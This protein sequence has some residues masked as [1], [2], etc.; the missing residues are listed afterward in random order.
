MQSPKLSLASTLLLISLHCLAIQVSSIDTLRQGENLNSTSQLISNNGAFSLRFYTPPNSNSTYLALWFTGRSRLSSPVWIGNRRNPIPTNSNPTL[1]LGARGQ[2]TITHDG[3]GAPIDLYAGRSSEVEN[4]TATLTDTGNF[5]VNSN[6]PAGLFWHS[7]DQPSDTLLGGMRLGVERS[8]KRNW[9]LTSWAAENDP[10]PGAYSM[11]WDSSSRNLVVRR[12][13]AAIWRSGELK[14]YRDEAGQSRAE[15]EN[16]GIGRDVFN[17]NFNFT[18][19]EEEEYVM[20]TVLPFPGSP[21][22]VLSGWRLE[23]DGDIVDVDRSMFLARPDAAAEQPAP[24][25]D[26]AAAGLRAW[27]GF[28]FAAVVLDLVLFVI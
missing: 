15:F 24:P 6:G 19:E 25:P 7:F 10:A 17:F 18:A 11:E 2:L 26:S 9:T 28:A 22:P 4:V 14:Y 8:I 27:A 21:A 3:G 16:V 13:G 5:L 12:R 23:S 1:T 20:F